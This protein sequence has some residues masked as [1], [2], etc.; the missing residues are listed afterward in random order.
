MG[1]LTVS[2]KV[3]DPS[4]CSRYTIAGE[5]AKE[6]EGGNSAACKKSPGRQRRVPSGVP[7][8]IKKGHPTPV[9]KREKKKWLGVSRHGD[10][11]G[12]TFWGRLTPPDPL[13]LLGTGKKFDGGEWGRGGQHCA[14]CL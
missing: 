11:P 6:A 7:Y 9:Q 2:F 3:R 8:D 4:G 14:Q 5:G 12:K 10:F 13:S 1:G